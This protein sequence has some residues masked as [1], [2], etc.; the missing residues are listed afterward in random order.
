MLLLTWKDTTLTWSAFKCPCAFSWCTQSG[1]RFYNS[2]NNH[3][4]CRFKMSF[5]FNS[6]ILFDCF[7]CNVLVYL[8]SKNASY[9][10]YNSLW[11]TAPVTRSLENPPILASD[12][13]F[14][15]QVF[16]I[17]QH[18]SVSALFLA[19]NAIAVLSR[20]RVWWFEPGISNVYITMW[21][22]R[23]FVL[24]G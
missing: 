8:L 3:P 23:F 1:S 18:P 13:D 5:T 6:N 22:I 16:V 15:V 21:Y 14:R 4:F 20:F 7:W 2:R 9:T 19:H 10:W 17:H 12:S 11:K 24:I